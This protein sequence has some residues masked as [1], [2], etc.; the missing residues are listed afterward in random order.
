MMPH[1][2]SAITRLLGTM[3]GLVVSSATMMKANNADVLLITGAHGTAE[4][5]EQFKQVADL[6]L[7]AATQSGTSVSL[8][9]THLEKQALQAIRQRLIPLVGKA[10]QEPLWIVLI[11]HG[12]SDGRESHFNLPGEDLAA[13]DLAELLSKAQREIILIDNTAASGP[14]I[15]ALSGAN[16]TIVTAT[17]GADQ[18]YLTR[19]GQ[20]F[21]QAIA[22]ESAADLDQDEQVSVLEAFLYG[23]AKTRQYY[24]K[25]DR[26]A[27]E[28]SL[29]DDN[30]DRQ[31]TRSE[32]FKVLKPTQAEGAPTPDGQ[33]AAQLH[34]VRTQQED[35]LSAA[36]RARRDELERAVRA[37][38]EKKANLAEATYYEQLEKLM[39]EIATITRDASQ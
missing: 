18:V 33:R 2:A 38:V 14:F 10:T 3:L 12:S 5:G 7:G 22:G 1:L 20:H 25:E 9:E 13:A 19:F 11:G 21:A 23:A 37:L 28:H 36:Q 30:G 17:K 4:Y 27:T 6:W 24:E 15:Q 32:I 29:L 39:R 8:L 26:I 34:L 35:R 16:R 31:G